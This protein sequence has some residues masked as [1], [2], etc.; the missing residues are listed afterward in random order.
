[1]SLNRLS[2]EV[3]IKEY[4]AMFNNL[5]QYL[6]KINKNATDPITGQPYLNKW[7]SESQIIL[8][9]VT[10]FVNQAPLPI[11]CLLAVLSIPIGVAN[12]ALLV[13]GQILGIGLLMASLPFMIGRCLFKD[14]GNQE[15][16]LNYETVFGL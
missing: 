3:L 9:E 7:Y 10:E 6:E 13:A 11:K 14:N 5:V 12:M 1:M 16:L 8:D 4:E 15:P 2:I